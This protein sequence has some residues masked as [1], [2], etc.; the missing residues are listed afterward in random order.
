MLPTVGSV[1][2]CIV[3]HCLYMTAPMKL[4]TGYRNTTADTRIEIEVPVA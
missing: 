3:F 2:L 4:S 1:G